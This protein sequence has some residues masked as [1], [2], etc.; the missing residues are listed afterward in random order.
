ML[1]RSSSIIF[2]TTDR[3][4]A[5][6][7]MP[8][9]AFTEDMWNQTLM[10]NYI[11]ANAKGWYQYVKSD[12][13]GRPVKNGHIRVVV[14]VDKV[15]SWGIATFASSSEEHVR[16]EF[17]GVSHNDGA[18]S[19]A[20]IWHCVGSGSGRVGPPEEEIRDLQN[21]RYPIRN[22]C[23][24]V[25]TL[26]FS[27]SKKIWDKLAVHEVL[28]SSNL[29]DCIFDSKQHPNGTAHGGSS[30]DQ[31]HSYFDQ[32]NVNFHN[33]QLGLSV[34]QLCTCDCYETLTLAGLTS[35]KCAK[36]AFIRKGS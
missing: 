26:N 33:T 14:G 1:I 16:F 35:I 23:V 29:Q 30:R 34:S 17:R 31:S 28:Q 32:E 13:C 2:E 5:I 25:R 3:E 9:G 21:D 36:H 27:L 12:E 18:A 6:L 19:Q 15:S 11:A 24:F 4:G 8:D 7:I 10:E 20:Y 22:Q